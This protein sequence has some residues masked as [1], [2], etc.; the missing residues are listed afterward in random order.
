MNPHIQKACELLGSGKNLAEAVDVS[1]Q[2]VTQM[3]RE[4]RPVP[5]R[6]APVIERATGGKVTRAQ[7]CPEVFGD[8]AAA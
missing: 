5:A 1:P 3:L 2:F 7:L 8:E 6:L 4:H